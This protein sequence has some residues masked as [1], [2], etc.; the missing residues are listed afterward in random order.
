LTPNRCEIR[1]ASNDFNGLSRPCC[2]RVALDPILEPNQE[3]MTEL[4]HIALIVAMVFA[5]FL[6]LLVMGK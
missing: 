3:N 4:F 1:S 6:V 2:I 5:P